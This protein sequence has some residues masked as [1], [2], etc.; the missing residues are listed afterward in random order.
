MSLPKWTDERT[1]QLTDFVGSESPV[2]QDTVA[3]AAEDLETSTRSVAS[4]LRKLGFEVQSA[5]EKS[6]V[7]AYSDDQ[8]NSLRDFVTSNSGDFTYAEIASRFDNGQFSAKSIQGKILSMEL[9]GHVKPTPKA[10]VVRSYTEAEEAVFVSMSN[11]GASIEAIAEKLGKTVPSARGKALSLLRTGEITAIPHQAN[12]A[13]A[14]ED[15]LTA[16][17][18]VSELTV[19]Q[20]A[21]ALE[22]TVRGVKTMLTKRGIKV[23][24]YDGAGRKEKAAAA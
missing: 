8:E 13:P 2:S 9:T 21:E 16:L 17:G 1:A 7:K 4:K 11:G 19:E 14:K 15:A 22:K 18:D 12:K 23:A 20:I 3:K 6:A 10:E 24:N 5:A